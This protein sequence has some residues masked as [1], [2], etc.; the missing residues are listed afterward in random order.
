MSPAGRGVHDPQSFDHLPAR[1]DR[2]GQL[3]GAELRAW[4]LFHLPV[5]GG[6]ALDA[7]CGTGLHTDLLADRYTDVLAVDLSAPMLA[8]ATRHRPH[9]NVRYEHRD[10]LDLT[11][12]GDGPFD[13]VFSAYTLHHV[14]DLPAALVHLRSLVRPGGTV[15]LVDVV[16]NRHPVPR[17]WLRAEAWRTF[18]ADLLGRRRA[19][20]D[21]AELLRLSL[22]PDWLDHQSTD[23]LLPPA[24]WDAITR[25]AFP[26]AGVT[27]LHRARALHWRA[28][29]GLDRM[30]NGR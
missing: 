28:P 17:S 2:Y 19:I 20:P 26:G 11:P 8:Y 3:V 13:L 7:G 22:D 25:D 1:Y 23:R 27:Y 18:R 16:D 5:H 29:N 30:A 10:L 12:A 9:P 15:L 4:L 24:E 6:R 21:A 14:A